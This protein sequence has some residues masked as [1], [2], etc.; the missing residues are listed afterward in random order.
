MNCRDYSTTYGLDHHIVVEDEIIAA[1]VIDAVA[2]GEIVDQRL[3][4]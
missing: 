3:L 1:T 2:T 4:K